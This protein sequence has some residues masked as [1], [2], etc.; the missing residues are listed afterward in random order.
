M[1][2]ALKFIES[3][4]ALTC[5]SGHPQ[6]SGCICWCCLFL[7]E[8]ILLDRL[9]FHSL[10]G[11][12]IPGEVKWLTTNS[13]TQDFFFKGAVTVSLSQVTA[14]RRGRFTITGRTPVLCCWSPT[15]ASFSTWAVDRRASHSTTWSVWSHLETPV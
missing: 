11:W 4:A 12:L 13:G 6:G 9:Y 5:E 3:F 14:E 10:S 7:F 8:C 1:E 15:I 2:E